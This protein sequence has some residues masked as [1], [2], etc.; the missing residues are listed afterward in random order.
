MWDLLCFS[1]MSIYFPWNLSSVFQ[2]VF[3][4][5]HISLFYILSVSVFFL[6]CLF[7]VMVFIIFS[8][9]KFFFQFLSWVLHILWFFLLW[10]LYFYFVFFHNCYCFL[11]DCFF[12]SLF[13]NV[14]LKFSS[15]SKQNFLMSFHQLL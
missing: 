11:K 4:F 10:V 15:A 6:W 14:I 9:S 13:G 12:R 8:I 7:S 2:Y 3:Y 1:F 5:I